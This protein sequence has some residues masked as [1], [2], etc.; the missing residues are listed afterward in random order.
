MGELAQVPHY[1]ERCRSGWLISTATEP[2]GSGRVDV[3]THPK[4]TVACT[5]GVVTGTADR[6]SSRY[7]F[8]GNRRTRQLALSYEGN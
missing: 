5:A 2:H 6:D 7:R 8:S 3:L 4:T 1:P